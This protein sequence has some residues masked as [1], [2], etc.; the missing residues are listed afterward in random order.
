MWE[1]YVNALNMNENILSEF[2]INPKTQ[3]HRKKML[4]K[5]WCSHYDFFKVFFL[6]LLE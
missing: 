3:M 1:N 5:F 4:G 2:Q 6:I